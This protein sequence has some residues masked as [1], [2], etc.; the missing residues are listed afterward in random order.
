MGLEPGTSNIEHPTTRSAP[1]LGRRNVGRERT[2]R[3]QRRVALQGAAGVS[4]ADQPHCL[5][6]PARWRVCV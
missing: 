2:Q 3:T 4:P 6:L 5:S 1:V